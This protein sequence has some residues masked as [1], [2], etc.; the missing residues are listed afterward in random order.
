M[1]H[2]EFLIFITILII[3]SFKYV[4]KDAHKPYHLTFR[5]SWAT[6]KPLSTQRT[7][8]II[9]SVSSE[10]SVVDYLSLI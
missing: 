7:Q 5:I 2:H 8:R 4:L 6:M 10:S 1:Q 9:H 3:I